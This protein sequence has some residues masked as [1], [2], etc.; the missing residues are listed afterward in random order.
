MIAEPAGVLEKPEVFGKK[1]VF[2]GWRW[3]VNR[4]GGLPETPRI[5]ARWWMDHVWSGEERAAVLRAWTIAP[6]SASEADWAALCRPTELFA[7]TGLKGYQVFDMESLSVKQYCMTAR[8]ATPAACLPILQPEIAKL[9]EAPLNRATDTPDVFGFLVTK[10]HHVVFKTLHK[11]TAKGSLIGAECASN[12]NLM[13]HFPRVELATELLKS[14]AAAD[15]IVPLLLD[16]AKETESTK[17]IA[18]T[19][20]AAVAKRFEGGAAGAAGAEDLQH[21]TD[22]SLHIVCPYLEFLL[23]YMDAKRIGGQRWFLSLLDTARST[24][25]T[26]M[27]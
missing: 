20:Q 27:S 6:P 13:H 4:F 22:L 1:E 15:P 7:G 23:R 11:P 8:D 2:Y 5:A 26:K 18:T 3:I 17:K 14:R 25:K 21:L 9:V 24:P 19:R 12:S 10:E 16:I